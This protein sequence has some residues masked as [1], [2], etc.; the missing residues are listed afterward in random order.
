MSTP[1]GRA[2]LILVSHGSPVP[3]WNRSM[4]RIGQS[5]K[6]LLVAR[7]QNPFKEVQVAHLEFAEPSIADACE[8]MES[9]G[10]ERIVAYPLFISVSSHSERDIPNALNTRYHEHSDPEIRRYLG[11][12]PVTYTT[13]MDHGPI[14]P[15][16]V[17]EC[18]KEISTDPS[19]ETALVFSHGDGCEHFWGHMHRRVEMAVAE[20]TGIRDVRCIGVQTGRSPASQD[21][22]TE[23]VESI[24]S[25]LPG[26]RIL[27]LSCFGGL[28]GNQFLT[29]I[30]DGLTRRG[31]PTVEGLVGDAGWQ[32]KPIVA[33]EIARVA[34]R[35]G[36]VSLG[37]DPDTESYPKDNYPPYN[38]PFWLTRDKK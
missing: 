19:N 14:L 16:V 32:D 15:S 28:S 20:S 18:A 2:G 17:A 13:P 30:N 38:P 27:V 10:C 29:R 34:H 8:Y 21:R 3:S 24:R 26:R 7:A 12:V 35:A 23:A 6:K 33:E 31:R 5:V 25:A 22:V 4:E 9:V 11:R 37:V 1:L 36:L